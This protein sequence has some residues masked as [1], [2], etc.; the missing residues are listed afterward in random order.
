MPVVTA[1]EL[2]C[3]IALSIMNKNVFFLATCFSM[4]TNREADIFL[5]DTYSCFDKKCRFF[6]F[7]KIYFF[8]TIFYGVIIFFN[9]RTIDIL[10]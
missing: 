4:G 10:G 1:L 9:N 3:E 5:K 2:H 8:L 7:W 6:L